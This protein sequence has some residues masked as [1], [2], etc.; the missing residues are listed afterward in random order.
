MVKGSPTKVNLRD[1]HNP[2][3]EYGL[4]EGR[5]EVTIP[6]FSDFTVQRS[7]SQ[8]SIISAQG[9]PFDGADHKGKKNKGKR[10]GTMA[11][12]TQEIDT[13]PDSGFIHGYLFQGDWYKRFRSLFLVSD[14]SRIHRLG[15][16][17][18]VSV[19]VERSRH[20][21]SFPNI[22]HPYSAFR[23]YWDILM[24]LFLLMTLLLDPVRMTFYAQL[25]NEGG[26][27]HVIVGIVVTLVYLTDIV[28][29]FRT[30]LVDSQ[31]DLVTLDPALIARNYLTTW[32]LIDLISTIPF[33]LIYM[34]TEK[35][36]AGRM[37]ASD[38]NFSKAVRLMELFKVFRLIRAIRYISRLL[39]V[40]F[41]NGLQLCT[42]K[43]I[44][45][46]VSIFNSGS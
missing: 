12:I 44:I 42:L 10:E 13:M 24:T 21:A 1:I 46:I 37:E 39:F 22:I 35:G 26:Q 7:E 9:H 15:Y 34:I 31:S 8:D 28:L 30:G 11:S 18:P 20:L 25:L 5:F 33:D 29:N 3:S 43:E 45:I 19:F 2:Y 40:S 4:G 6:S 38:I 41:Q 16:R 27:A 23:W 17:S 14:R 36:R 32:F